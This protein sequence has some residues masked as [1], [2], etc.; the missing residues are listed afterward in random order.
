VLRAV[1][2]SVGWQLGVLWIVDKTANELRCVDLCTPTA[3]RP[4]DFEAKRAPGTIPRL[5]T[6]PDVGHGPSAWI[7]DVVKEPRF[8]APGGAEAAGLHAAFSFPMFLED[9]VVGVVEFF[10]SMVLEPD[11]TI[12][13][14]SPRSGS[15]SARCR[16]TRAQEQVERFFTMSQDLL[17]IA[18][19]DGISSG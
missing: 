1:A 10:T 5:R 12:F 17:C 14:C 9:E 13:G 16:R 7:V 3:W 2:E 8:L 11:D 18:G 6:G 4:S 15:S 19:F